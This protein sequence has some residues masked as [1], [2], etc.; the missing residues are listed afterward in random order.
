[1]EEALLEWQDL[2]NSGDPEKIAIVTSMV[3]QGLSLDDAKNFADLVSYQHDLSPV[4]AFLLGIVGTVQ[5]ALEYALARAADAAAAGEDASL[6]QRIVNYLS[7]SGAAEEEAGTGA[8]EGAGTATNELGAAREKYV[9]DQVGAT[10]TN[11]IVDT[12][13]G[14]Y[15]VDVVS[16]DGKYIEVGGPSKD[17]NTFGTQ[18]KKLT[19]YAESQGGTAQFYYQQGTPEAILNIARRWLGSENVIPYNLPK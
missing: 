11:R 10:E 6:W 19:W 12:P 15:D 1:M 7:G 8:S 14:K 5:G 3:Q 2:M 18:M 9:A 17:P 4:I 16:P 13:Y